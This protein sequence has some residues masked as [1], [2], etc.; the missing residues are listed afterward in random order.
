MSNKRPSLVNMPKFDEIQSFIN[1]DERAAAAVAPPVAAEQDVQAAPAPKAET[2]AAQPKRVRKAITES[3]GGGKK[4]SFMLDRD[5]HRQLKILAIQQ[6]RQMQ[7]VLEE[8]I[9]T[10]I[11]KH[12]GA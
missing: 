11:R 6:D 10:H 4:T 9:R 7:D 3:A 1:G 12:S 2:A 5:L 8:A